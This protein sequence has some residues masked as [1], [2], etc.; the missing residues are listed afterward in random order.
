MRVTEDQNQE[1]S[2]EACTHFRKAKPGDP[3]AGWRVQSPKIFELRSRWEKHL[4]ERALFEQQ[5]F[6]ANLAFDFEPQAYPYCA[7]YSKE[8]GTTSAGRPLQF[9]LCDRQNPDKDCPDFVPFVPS[10]KIQ[11]TR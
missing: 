4:A 7:H 10:E 8:Y 6:E 5:R 3:L 1:R 2:C 11:S 9:I